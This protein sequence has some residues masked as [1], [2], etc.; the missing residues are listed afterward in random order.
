[1]VINEPLMAIIIAGTFFINAI[2]IA[3]NWTTIN[4]PLMVTRPCFIAYSNTYA[5][6]SDSSDRIHAYFN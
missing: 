4:G 2:I 1:M 5:V 3:G 6:V